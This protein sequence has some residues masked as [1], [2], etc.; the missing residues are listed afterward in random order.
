MEESFESL[1]IG[2]D[3]SADIEQQLFSSH[4]EELVTVLS[5]IDST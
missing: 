1:E 2:Q 5:V 3:S 4:N